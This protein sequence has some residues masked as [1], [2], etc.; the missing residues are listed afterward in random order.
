L[1]TAAKVGNRV[2]EI[3]ARVL[4]LLDDKDGQ[5]LVPLRITS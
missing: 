3:A 4:R 1:S 5:A 2:A